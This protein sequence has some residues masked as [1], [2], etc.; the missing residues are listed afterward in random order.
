VVDAIP[1]FYSEKNPVDTNIYI[2][3]RPFAFSLSASSLVFKVREVS[4]V[5]DTGYVD[6]S[7]LCTVATFDAGGGLL[8]L[9]ITYNPAVDFHYSAVIY[10]SL[11]VYDVAPTPNIILT[12]YWFKIIPDFKG[13]YIINEIP[14]REEEDV[15][16]STDISFDIYDIGVGV[17]TSTLEL[18]VNNRRVFPVVSVIPGGYHVDYDPAVDF[19]YGETVE[20]TVK[21]KDSSA[22]QNALYDSWRFYCVGST[23]PWIDR[24][25][26]VPK[27]CSRGIARRVSDISFNVYAVDDTG[28]DE[29]SILVTIGG[30]NRNITITPIVYRID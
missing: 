6:V 28:V 21:A 17:D 27:N 8:G 3:I 19:Y 18:Y 29:F 2:R 30:K 25:S 12:D 26:F 5:G 22:Y 23:G 1:P 15:L 9:D 24:T 7:S 14:S 13:P 20:V 10:V 11:E 16:I 4:Y